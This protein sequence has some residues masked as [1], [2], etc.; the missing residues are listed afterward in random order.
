MKLYMKINR[1]QWVYMC[2]SIVDKL[3]IEVVMYSNTA[4]KR[5]IPGLV[6]KSSW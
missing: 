6:I 2:Y 1:M 4:S 3:T 5:K